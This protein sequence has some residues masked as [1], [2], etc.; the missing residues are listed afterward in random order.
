MIDEA[1][2]EYLDKIY[3]E[4]TQWL[5]KRDRVADS[6]KRKFFCDMSATPYYY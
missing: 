4:V 6:T 5:N 2:Y 1:Y 3:Q